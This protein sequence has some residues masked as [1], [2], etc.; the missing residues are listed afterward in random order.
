MA[1]W[2]AFLRAINLGPTR[3][4]PMSAVVAATEAAGGTDIATHLATGNV[5]LSSTKRSA[6]AVAKALAAAYAADR[7]FD[8]P[9]VVRRPQEIVDLLDAIAG[10]PDPHPD[11]RTYV[12]FLDDPARETVAAELE[13]WDRPGE[14]VRVLDR[15]VVLRLAVPF[16]EAPKVTARIDRA[17]PIVTL[18]DLRVVRAFAC[19]WCAVDGR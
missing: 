11:G 14:F 5:R 1:T 19:R 9:V 12:A 10:L 16:H 18:R 2:I 3:K 13:S 8:V 15:H 6:A 4:F 17:A 7:G